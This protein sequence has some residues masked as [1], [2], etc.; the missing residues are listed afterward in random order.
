MSRCVAL[1]L[2]LI[3][4][5]EGV[6]EGARGIV[7]AA[8]V[9]AGICV[10]AG[11]G[12][13]RL[14]GELL[15]QGDFVVHGVD[16]DRENV[17]RARAALAKQRIYGQVS[18]DQAKGGRLPYADGM[19][20]LLVLDDP[21]RVGAEY[22]FKEVRRVL[23]PGGVAVV[24][25]AGFG[26]WAGAGV[27]AR[28]ENGPWAVFAKERPAG[29]DDWTHADYDASGVAVSR[30]T[31][32][33][34]LQGIRWVAGPEWPLGLYYQVGNGGMVSAGGRL[35]GV[36]IHVAENLSKDP[37]E[38]DR[39]YYLT[40]RDAYNGK[41]LWSR[42]LPHRNP[43]QGTGL[44]HAVVADGNRIFVLLDGTLLALDAATGEDAKS[45]AKTESQENRVAL[46]D[47]VLVLG[48][49]KETRA[50][51]AATGSTKW[52][53][54]VG[55]E[56]LLI[57]HGSVFVTT[58][59]RKELVC[60]ALRDGKERWRTDLLPY[61]KVKRRLLFVR[62]GFVV[63]VGMESTKP[64][65]NGIAVFSA[66]DGRLLWNKGYKNPRAHWPES[67]HYLDGLIWIRTGK[68]HFDGLDPKTGKERRRL[69]FDGKLTGGCFRNIATEK[70][71]FGTRPINLIDL[72]DG[73]SHE[74][75]GG[76]HACRAGVV[77]ANGL[78]YTMPHGCKCVSS[79][80]RGFLAFA[81][82]SDTPPAADERR[83]QGP[84][85]ADKARAASSAGDWPTY[86]HDP[87]RTGRTKAAGPS[88]LDLLWE[89]RVDDSLAPGGALGKEWRASSA[90]GQRMTGPVVAGSVAA[91]SCVQTHRVVA[92]ESSTGKER[93]RFTTGARIDTPPTLHGGRCTF[94]SRDGWV[95]SLRAS[96]G[97]L[98][99]K[100]RGAPADER[101]LAFGQL[102][103]R[104]PVI[105]GVTVDQDR[106]FFVAGRSGAVDGGMIAYALDSETGNVVWETP[107]TRGG[108]GDVGVKDGKGILLGRLLKFDLAT[109]RP[110]RGDRNGFW[111]GS[112][113]ILDRAWE[114][115]SADDRSLH[116]MRVKQGFGAQSA[117]SM[118]SIKHKFQPG[119]GS[120]VVGEPERKRVFAFRVKYIHWNVKPRDRNERGGSLHAW[121]E[122]KELWTVSIPDDFQIESLV[123]A[124]NRLYAA[125]PV[126]RFRRKAGGKVWILSADDGRLLEEKAIGTRPVSEGLAVAGGRLY[127][128]LE[129]GRLLCFGTK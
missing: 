76:R 47:G 98:A 38:R 101:I 105:G 37:L 68:G 17:E 25:K 96:D 82:G 44:A 60:L 24:A 36:T 45:Y 118:M 64:G 70:Y 127:V 7:A 14:A 77:V 119:E 102:E 74:F 41:L 1:V 13:G 33:G 116:W 56:D 75:R 58:P 103:S 117:I 59:R 86:R 66:S 106:L 81:P 6:S 122:G 87:E 121:Q 48:G 107:V 114:T 80:L 78:F 89:R 91:V 90:A 22:P 57:D 55:A 9:R 12:D 4:G 83:I 42:L 124:G 126:D 109:G 15:R 97:A 32:I 62:D 27:R 84:A 29:M 18:V 52:S 61:G 50:L 111:S 108:R 73:K 69:D 26:A 92:V 93:W 49:Q 120:L 30:D 129:D 99:W 100:F 28:T 95:Y 3:P 54:R 128:S 63:F 35:F 104:W 71:L 94:G 112:N 39:S 20:N 125:G 2:A 79:A 67:I 115:L 16:P 113:R 65:T 31:A 51:D 23:C 11:C 53:G 46:S 72:Q 85:A 8:G 34:P 88:N 43:R 123:L 10:H 5:Q 40:A 110:L 19:I 21:E